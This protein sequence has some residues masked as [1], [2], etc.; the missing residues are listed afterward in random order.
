MRDIRDSRDLR[1]HRDLRDLRDPRDLRDLRDTR[2]L[3][4]SRDFRDS[5]DLRDMREPRDGRMN[6]YDDFG[7]RLPPDPTPGMMFDRPIAPRRQL[8]PTREE[9]YHSPHRPP[10]RQAL[11]V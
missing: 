7:E 5:R 10:T 11:N 3:R 2:D 6:R 8:P 9:D 1:D 4:D